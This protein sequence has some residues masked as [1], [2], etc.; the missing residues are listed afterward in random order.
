MKELCDA[1]LLNIF[2]EIPENELINYW[3][4]VCLADPDAAIMV[5][6]YFYKR[7]LS[8]VHSQFS[9]LYPNFKP[10]PDYNWE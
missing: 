5:H 1:I 4:L 2:E 8:A 7:L 9:D 3:T 10:L 6:K